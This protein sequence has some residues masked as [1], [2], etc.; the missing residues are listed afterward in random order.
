MNSNFVGCST[1]RSAGLAFEDLVQIASGAPYQIDKVDAIAHKPTVFH[2]FWRIIYCRHA[3]LA[4][5]LQY[6]LS[7]RIEDAL[8]HEGGLRAFFGYTSKRW[9]YLFRTCDVDEVKLDAE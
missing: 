6:L 8:Q 4:N 9:L 1:G 2:P 3:A 5:E 7:P